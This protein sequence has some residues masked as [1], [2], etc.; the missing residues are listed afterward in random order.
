VDGSSLRRNVSGIADA[1]ARLSVNL[2]GA[3]AMDTAEFQLLRARPRT[4]I[5][6]SIMIQ[7]PTGGYEADKLINLGTKRWAVKPALGLIWPI[8]PTWL[9]EF[10]I[11]AWFYSDNDDFLGTTRQQDPI[12]SSELHLVKRLRPG[13]WV[14]LDLNYYVGGQ[15][16]VGQDLLT[17][18]QR[19]SRIGGTA[20]FPFNGQSAI[21]FSYSTGIVTRSGGDFSSYSLSYLFAW[22]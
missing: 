15:T 22:R 3:P 9:V 17:D 19:N 14:S 4:I 7:A 18:L 2:L 5:G 8:H 12:L 21:R 16:Q 10:E 1:R 6:A 11:G 20:V 13:F